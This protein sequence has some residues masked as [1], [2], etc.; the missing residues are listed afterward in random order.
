M[1]RWR[2]YAFGRD[3]E[4]PWVEA[5]FQ[6]S[7]TTER[8]VLRYEYLTGVKGFLLMVGVSGSASERPRS[9]PYC[10]DPLDVFG[11]RARLRISGGIR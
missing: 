7:S 6:P 5:V 10:A 4:N 2:A 1:P 11:M 8:E 9:T 3:A